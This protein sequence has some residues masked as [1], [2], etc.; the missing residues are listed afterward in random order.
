MSNETI[1]EVA[2]ISKSFQRGVRVLDDLTFSL[3]RGEIVALIGASGSGKSTLIRTLSGLTPVDTSRDDKA[4]GRITVLGRPIQNRGKIDCARDLRARIGVIF[5]QFNL[6]PRLSL[7]ANVCLGLLG[8]MP[9][10]QGVFG[11][12]SDKE[13]LK[14]MQALARV[15]IAEHALKR[16]S[17][18]S[19]GQQQR[20]A[21]ARTLVQGAELLIADEPIAS[22]DPASARR[23]MDLIADMNRRDGLTV[24]ISLHQVEYALKYC[25]RTIAL[26]AGKIAYDGPSSALTPQF[27]NQIYGAESEELFLSPFENIAASNGRAAEAPSPWTYRPARRRPSR[28]RATRAKPERLDA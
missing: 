5:Q 8:R 4:G 22:L 17:E 12:F 20:A 24:F 28:S 26:K 2:N 15:G 16:A 25:P 7:L 27:L 10:I 9:T 19:G 3:Q 1:V 18:L 23:V 11:Y 6:V 13:K 14:A 21:I